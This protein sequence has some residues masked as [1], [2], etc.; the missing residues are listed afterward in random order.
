MERDLQAYVKKLEQSNEKLKAFS[1]MLVH[2]IKSPLASVTGFLQILEEKNRE[3]FDDESRELLKDLQSV[4]CSMFALVDMLHEFAH[5]ESHLR[6]FTD[7]DMEA[8]FY[9]VMLTCGRRSRPPAQQSRT[10]P[11]RP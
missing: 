2:E 4:V 6:E 9:Q 1:H 10:T 5:F 11:C 8:V 7:V 3:K